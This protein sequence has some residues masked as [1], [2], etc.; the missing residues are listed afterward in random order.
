MA[1][2]WGLDRFWSTRLAINVECS[3]DVTCVMLL[4]HTTFGLS[5]VNGAIPEL[6][7]CRKR[8]AFRDPLPISARLPPERIAMYQKQIRSLGA[9]NIFPSRNGRTPS[10]TPTDSLISILF[11]D[12]FY[13]LCLLFLAFI[14]PASSL[15]TS[16][17]EFDQRC[18]WYR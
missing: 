15:L 16:R 17:R 9:R 4:P 14:S 5:G 7:R 10:P 12:D 18:D 1:W 6:E 3:A 2:G 11:N 8:W 13:P